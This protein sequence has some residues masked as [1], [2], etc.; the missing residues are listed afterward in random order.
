MKVDILINI[1]IVIFVTLIVIEH[2]MMF[3]SLISEKS[4]LYTY[5][6]V[7]FLLKVSRDDLSTNH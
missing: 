1:L 4:L 2:F 7:M 3:N 5:S 6:I